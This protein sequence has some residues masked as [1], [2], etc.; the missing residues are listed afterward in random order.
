MPAETY[1]LIC[2]KTYQ[3]FEGCMSNNHL[4][5]IG[6]ATSLEQAIQM[7]EEYEEKLLDQGTCL[8]Y[9]VFFTEKVRGYEVK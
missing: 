6:S 8:E 1:L 5:T 3:I 7:A 9:G 4:R 2:S